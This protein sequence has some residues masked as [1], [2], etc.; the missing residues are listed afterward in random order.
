MRRPHGAAFWGMPH[1]TCVVAPT[2]GPQCHNSLHDCTGRGHISWKR[3][4]VVIWTQQIARLHRKGPRIAESAHRV[5]TEPLRHA[6]SIPI[7]A[8]FPKVAH[9]G[10]GGW[11]LE[12]KLVASGPTGAPFP[13]VAHLR[14]GGWGLGPLV[15]TPP[16]SD[17]NIGFSFV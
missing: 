14:A 11:E 10:A 13:K 12:A 16:Y 2:G 7:G 5:T 9:L 17:S 6:F 4:E 15:D 3:G 8:Q 1:I